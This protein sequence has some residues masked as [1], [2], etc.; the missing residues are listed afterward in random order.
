VAAGGGGDKDITDSTDAS[1]VQ[2]H[3]GVVLAARTCVA[4]GKLRVFYFLNFKNY[5]TWPTVI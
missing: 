5:A 3:W 1:F 2:G 4:V